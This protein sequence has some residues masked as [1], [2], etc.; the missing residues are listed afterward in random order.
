MAWAPSTSF[1]DEWVSLQPDYNLV[2][3]QLAY[4]IARKQREYAP[5]PD[6]TYDHLARREQLNEEIERQHASKSRAIR[7]SLAMMERIQEIAGTKPLGEHATMS[8]WDDV[9]SVEK[10][11]IAMMRHF[12]M[13]S[14]SNGALA[15]SRT[16]LL[17]QSD[18]YILRNGYRQFPLILD[19]N[20]FE[21][22]K[23]HKSANDC[24]AP[25]ESGYYYSAWEMKGTEST[26]T[27][28]PY[29]CAHKQTDHDDTASSHSNDSYIEIPYKRLRNHSHKRPKQSTKKKLSQKHNGNH[30]L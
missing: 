17:Q 13:M 16:E 3:G 9:G 7:A 26:D 1:E 11:V 28:S 24:D 30:Q 15:P 23:T 4:E 29:F 10:E 12:G 8:D 6:S 2:H 20:Y 25:H 14:M 18:I 21:P 19:P 5:R 22:G 27:D